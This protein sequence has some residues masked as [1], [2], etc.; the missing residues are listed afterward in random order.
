MKFIVTEDHPSLRLLVSELI[1]KKIGA[2]PDDIQ[3]C[4]TGDELLEVVAEHAY[5]Q[6]VVVADLLMPGKYRRLQLIKELRKRAPL[7]R[8]VVYSGYESPHLAQELI[9]H[10]VL[11]YVFKSSPVTWLGWAI[12][13]AMNGERFIDPSLD[14]AH[15]LKIPWWDLTVRESD[16]V[17]ALCRGW[18]TEKICARYKM[19]GKTLSAH[20]RAAMVKL[21]V[22]E[23]AGL[24]AYLLENGLDFLLD[25]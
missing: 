15:N 17:V 16:V 12:S 9:F 20:K 24:T 11:G 2:S 8:I 18:S 21:G 25:E 23:E 6:A 10:G 3:H 4:N 22:S 19:K 5:S 14:T 7:A 13:N 1:K